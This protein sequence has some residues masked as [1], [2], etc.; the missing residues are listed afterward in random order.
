[1]VEDSFLDRVNALDVD[2]S[3]W[4]LKLTIIS[5]SFYKQKGEK[6]AESERRFL[7]VELS[8]GTTLE[9]TF[10]QSTFDKI[11]TFNSDYRQKV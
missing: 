5:Y 9:Q 8:V 1:M 11:L 4:S 6:I 2:L 7:K 3:S 10:V